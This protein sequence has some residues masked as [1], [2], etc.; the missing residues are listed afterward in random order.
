MGTSAITSAESA[1][2]KRQQSLLGRLWTLLADRYA[3]WLF[4]VPPLLILVV[5]VAYPTVYLV[6]LALSR[7]EIAFMANPEFVGLS[8]FQHLA[9]DQNFVRS[10]G[11]TSSS[12]SGWDW[13]SCF[14]SRCAARGS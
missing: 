12:W 5:L 11:N 8:N 4:V 10:S 9:T 14:T 13:L 6:Q 2:W 1:E 3:A 7:F